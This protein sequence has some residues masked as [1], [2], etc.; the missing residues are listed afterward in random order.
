MCLTCV[1]VMIR[2][3]LWISRRGGASSVFFNGVGGR[4]V[5]VQI[6]ERMRGVLPGE[7]HNKQGLLGK[8]CDC[9]HNR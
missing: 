4:S 6:R 7:M 2:G 9:G 8:P 5:V 1:C 3:C